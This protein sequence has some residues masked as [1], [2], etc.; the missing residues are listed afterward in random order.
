MVLDGETLELRKGD[1]DCWNMLDWI[2]WSLHALLT[3]GVT[4]S[5]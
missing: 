4:S 3:L 2:A 1:I 5:A